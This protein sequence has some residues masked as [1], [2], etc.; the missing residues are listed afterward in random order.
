M[1]SI[2]NKR[3]MIFDVKNFAIHD[4]TGI[5]TTVFLKGCPLHCIWCHNPESQKFSKEIVTYWDKCLTE[6]QECVFECPSKS[7]IKKDK[8]S[9]TNN[10]D[11]CGKCVEIC[12][13]NAIKIIGENITVDE[14]IN[15]IKSD[16][17]FYE[18]SNGGITFSGGE[19]LSQSGFLLELL[20]A[21]KAL[22]INTIVDTSGFSEWENFKKILPYTDL[23]FYD[24]KLIDEQK[25][26]EFTTVSNKIVLKNLIALSKLTSNIEIRIPLIPNITDTDD[27]IEAILN[28]LKKLEF[29]P[30]ISLLPFH[31]TGFEKYKRLRI[32]NK[33]IEFL[34][35]RKRNPELISKKF[36]AAGYSVKIGG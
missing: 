15:R 30:N 18:N 25:H 17:I 21:V 9:I 29:K 24:L 5:R 10:C 28:F 27:N 3:G 4:G 34:I 8:I 6:C 1:K 26:I 32:E 2:N 36:E 22:G 7:I 23:F 16:I 14:V 11:F 19:P 12:P 20:K 13:T 35:D 31:N 33:M